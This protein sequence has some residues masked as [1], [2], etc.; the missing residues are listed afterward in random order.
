ML[1]ISNNSQFAVHKYYSIDFASIDFVFD[2]DPDPDVDVDSKQ[3]SRAAI[4]ID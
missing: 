4:P 3:D 2:P 1:K